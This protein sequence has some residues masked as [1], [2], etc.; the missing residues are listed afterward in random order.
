MKKS[1]IVS[2]QPIE[3]AGQSFAQ[4]AKEYMEECLMLKINGVRYSVI[5][6]I[7]S[8]NED[9]NKIKT[10]SRSSRTT[11]KEIYL[12]INFGSITIS[13]GS[14]VSGDSMASSSKAAAWL[15]ISD[16]NCSTVAIGGL[17]R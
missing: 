9:F 5:K 11:Y 16:G 17:S 1:E 2:A 15:P 3:L 4:I 7:V 10:R 8:C 6:N 13:L 12:I 14:Y